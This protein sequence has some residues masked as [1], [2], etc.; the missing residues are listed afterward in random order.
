VL[1]AEQ[2]DEIIRRIA[3]LQPAALPALCC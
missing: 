3:T 2:C 1:A